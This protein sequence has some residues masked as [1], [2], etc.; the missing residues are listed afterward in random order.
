[1]FHLQ[2]VFIKMGINFTL[3]INIVYVYGVLK[4]VYVCAEHSIMEVYEKLS[5]KMITHAFHLLIL[6]TT[7]FLVLLFLSPLFFS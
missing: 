3:R 5:K 6:E 2:Y 7:F 4:Y 1:M